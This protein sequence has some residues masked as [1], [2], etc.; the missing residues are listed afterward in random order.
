MRVT[1]TPH[2]TQYRNYSA[3]KALIE[4]MYVET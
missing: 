2:T 1:A 3:G 4:Y